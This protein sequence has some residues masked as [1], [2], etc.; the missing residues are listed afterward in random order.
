MAK[1]NRNEYL[2]KKANQ[3]L[4]S[5]ER[6]A[7]GK[8]VPSPGLK[9]ARNTKEG[10]VYPIRLPWSCGI[11]GLQSRRGPSGAGLPALEAGR[12]WSISAGLP[13]SRDGVTIFYR[14]QVLKTSNVA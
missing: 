1:Y 2:V 8:R 3:F 9:P 10:T 13:S 7:E 4:D 12:L 14:W 5:M 11:G 6:R